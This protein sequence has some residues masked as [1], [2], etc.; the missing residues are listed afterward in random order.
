M[1]EQ[2]VVGAGREVGEDRLDGDRLAGA[3]CAFDDARHRAIQQPRDAGQEEQ[4]GGAI[5]TDQAPLP[6]GCREALQDVGRLRAGR[7]P[8]PSPRPLPG[9][10]V[11]PRSRATA[12][13]ALRSFSTSSGTSS[14]PAKWHPRRCPCGPP[15]G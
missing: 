6:A 3:G 12:R 1:D 10:A 9:S 8:R 14:S 4:L 2:R 11:R 7:P 5:L 15:A 13:A